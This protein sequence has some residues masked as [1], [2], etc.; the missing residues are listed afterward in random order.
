MKSSS[1]IHLPFPALCGR[2][3]ILEQCCS[4]HPHN[5]LPHRGGGPACWVRRRIYSGVVENNKCFW[6]KN[7]ANDP[8]Q[9]QNQIFFQDLSVTIPWT[10]LLTESCHFTISGLTITLQVMSWY[11][12]QLHSLLS[13]TVLAWTW[14]VSVPLVSPVLHC[15]QPLV[16]SGHLWPQSSGHWP[17]SHDDI[18]H[19]HHDLPRHHSH[20]W[21]CRH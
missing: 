9:I 5:Q 8:Q 1:E 18:M 19:H 17:G 3:D 14:P 2:S 12:L 16:T 4:Q 15:V 11:Y 6:Q 10:E 13:V 20:C 7:F 21:Q